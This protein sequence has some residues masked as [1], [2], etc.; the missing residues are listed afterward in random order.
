MGHLDLICANGLR[1][2]DREENLEGLQVALQSGELLISIIEDILDL[3]KIEAGQLDI[4]SRSFSLR[5]M[6]KQ[7]TNLARAYQIQKEKQHVALNV[8]VDEH[9]VDCLS[10]DDC[11]IRQILNNLIS[12]AVK[13]TASGSVTLNVDL[14]A[15]AKELQFSVKDT[16]KGIP[17]NHLDVVFDPFRQVEF[18]DTRN[19]GG[20][21]LGLTICKK[22][23]ELMGGTIRVTSST[24]P[25][26]HGSQ[27]VFFVPYV[28]ADV[29]NTATVAEPRSAT[30]DRALALSRS[31]QEMEGSK[32]EARPKHAGKILLA[33]DDPVSRRIATRMLEKIGYEVLV[34]ED[35]LQAV[36]IF[37]EH[38][39]EIIFILCDVMM[40]HM[41]GLE[42]TKRIRALLSETGHPRDLPIIALSA[43]AM[44]G[45]REKSLEFGMT[46]YLTKPV[47]FRELVQTLQRYIHHE[48]TYD[49][50]LK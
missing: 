6:I 3:S 27:F 25:E 21:G 39:S 36:S 11:R 48:G 4:Q 10:G 43:G 24:S 16:G 50:A 42:A 2:Q 37:Q 47:H 40:P 17:L 26:N 7:T 29:E 30:H 35:G 22:L 19:H 8:K 49:L 5:T 18:G 44:K 28:L 34:A 15:D 32:T 23:V 31:S 9:I 13:F 12:N 14:S 20:T 1:E 41:D 33:E 45:D 38:E 46:D